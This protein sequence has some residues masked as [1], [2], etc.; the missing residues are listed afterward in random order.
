MDVVVYQV[1]PDPEVLE[2]AR[3]L[4]LPVIA[5]R[6]M[7]RGPDGGQRL[8][9]AFAH[10]EIVASHRCVAVIDNPDVIDVEEGRIDD[11]GL[12]THLQRAVGRRDVGRVVVS[13]VQRQSARKRYVLHERQFHGLIA[14]KLQVFLVAYRRIGQHIAELI[15]QRRVRDAVDLHGEIDRAGEQGDGQSALHDVERAEVDGL[16]LAPERSLHHVH[17]IVV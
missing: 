12:E 10:E 14:E 17:G 4:Y 15:A 1:A 6:E 2:C 5:A 16:R 13:S 3:Y 7:I 11:K 9:R 8:H